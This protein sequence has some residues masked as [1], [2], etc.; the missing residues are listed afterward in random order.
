MK[1]VTAILIHYRKQSILAKA[2]RSLQPLGKRLTSILVFQEKQSKL[3]EEYKKDQRIHFISIDGK[4]LGSMINDTVSHLTSSHVLFLSDPAYLAP[5]AIGNVLQ[6]NRPVGTSIYHRNR[7]LWKPLLIPQAY[8]LERPLLPRSQLPF[9]EALLPA[10]L[11]K[12]N[13]ESW[14][15]EEK[16][17]KYSQMNTSPDTVQKS[18]FL[19]KY[20]LP[21]D[22]IHNNPSISV[23]IAN[24][25]MGSYLGAAIRSCFLQIEP[26][27]EV[28]VVDDGSTDQSRELL[29]LWDRWKDVRVVHKQNEGKAQALNV[30]L[31]HVTTD[32]VL[33]LDSDDWL[34]PDAIKIAKTYLTELPEDTSLLYGNL[35]KWK[36]QEEEED[37]FYK[38][39]AQGMAVRDWG[40]LKHYPFPMGPRIYRTSLLKDHGGF[41]V[42][43]FADG[44]LYEDVSVLR[45]LIKDTAFCYRNFTVYNVREHKESI[46][47]QQ[48]TTWNDF[49]EALKKEKE[50]SYRR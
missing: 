23:M 13:S 20:Q 14:V 3:D 4:D 44:R 8:L 37:V 50:N 43:E 39:T 10:W 33:E 40:Q 38:T 26:P 15:W 17:I 18:N 12:V 35:R 34:D 24:Y 29:K 27:E 36:Q 11:F 22:A 46:T 9:K 48:Q 5:H 6:T 47:N 32:F 1:D 31:P 49:I 41:P 42:L 45:K 25:N 7:V 19:Y 28:L 16:L 30:L 21:N 2:L